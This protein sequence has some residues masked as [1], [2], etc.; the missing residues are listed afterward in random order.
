MSERASERAGGRASERAS[1]RAI[2]WV[3][4]SVCLMAPLIK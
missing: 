1:E 2:G 4:K 3:G